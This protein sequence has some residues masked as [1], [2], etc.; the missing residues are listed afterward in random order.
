ML[1]T[2]FEQ[3][4]DTPQQVSWLL[5]AAASDFSKAASSFSGSKA[6]WLD[7]MAEL[8]RKVSSFIIRGVPEDGPKALD[9]LFANMNLVD[10]FC[11]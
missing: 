4:Q 2:S 7:K 3:G 1:R 6:D 11:S 8:S 5:E 9:Q 10:Q